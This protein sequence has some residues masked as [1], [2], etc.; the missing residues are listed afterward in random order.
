MVTS[1]FEGHLIDLLEVEGSQTDTPMLCAD[2]RQ[3][4]LRLPP[5]RWL[6]GM[7]RCAGMSVPLSPS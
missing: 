7:P 1:S 6:C 2:S 5:L 3:G 4:V